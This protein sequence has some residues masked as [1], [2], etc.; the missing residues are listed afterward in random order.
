MEQAVETKEKKMTIGNRQNVTINRK[1]RDYS[2]D[3]LIVKKA[4][5]AKKFLGKNGVP[6]R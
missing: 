2:K 6:K 4:E 5:A 1:M 3:P